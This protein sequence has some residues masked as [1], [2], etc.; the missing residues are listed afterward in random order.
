MRSKPTQVGITGGIGSGKS[1]VC[2]IFA[3]LGTPIYDADT[4]AKTLMTSDLI[5]IES[6]KA[7][8]GNLSYS[9]DGS[10]NR[11]YLSKE[12][13]GE[14][15]K[16]EK[17]NSLV[18]PRVQVDYE[19]WLT[20]NSESPYVVKEAALLFESGSYTSLDYIIGVSA[21]LALRVERVV[22]RDKHRT[23]DDIL[24]IISK[25]LPEEEKLKK[26]SFVVVNDETD[27]VIP[28]VLKLHER[29]IHGN[30]DELAGSYFRL[31]EI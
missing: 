6:I 16:L 27:L 29:F 5:L 26:A 19:K 31:F 20:Q 15:E 11:E 2:K 25:Q 18:H 12:A 21:S 8:F 10:L 23:K 1:M 24:K 14:N 9:N 13:F 3:T 22:A 28:Q 4:R 30:T 7:E 17:L